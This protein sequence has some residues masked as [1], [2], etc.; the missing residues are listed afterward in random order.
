MIQKNENDGDL[1]KIDKKK[2]FNIFLKNK[3]LK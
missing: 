2:E 3:N 1:E